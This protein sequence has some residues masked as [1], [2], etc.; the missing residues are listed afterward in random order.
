MKHFSSELVSDRVSERISE[1]T[2]SLVSCGLFA[3]PS[4]PSS[5][6]KAAPSPGSQDVDCAHWT[7]TPP[8]IFTAYNVHTSQ[9]RGIYLLTF[10]NLI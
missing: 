4:G 7:F 8:R 1:T 10:Y 9:H 5:V 3:E 6:G 2:D